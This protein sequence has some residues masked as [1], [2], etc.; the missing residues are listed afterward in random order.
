MSILITRKRT[1]GPG[2]LHRGTRCSL[3]LDSTWLAPDLTTPKCQ[4]SIIRQVNN[5]YHCG[6]VDSKT[7][8]L[9]LLQKSED[10]GQ[11]W[12]SVE[13]IWK[14]FAAYCDLVGVVPG[15]LGIFY[16]R[17]D[18]SEMACTHGTLEP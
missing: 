5:L 9:L 12:E 18:Y 15:I 13:T 3:R 4:S 2:R 10:L 8:T 17:Q 16:E 11:H 14:G 6:P 1:Q 7:H